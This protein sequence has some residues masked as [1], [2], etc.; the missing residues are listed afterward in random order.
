[1]EP[2]VRLLEAGLKHGKQHGGAKDAGKGVDSA[3]GEQGGDVWT[4]A[5]TSGSGGHSII[6]L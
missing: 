6:Y 5:S 1:M 3:V 2:E 4:M